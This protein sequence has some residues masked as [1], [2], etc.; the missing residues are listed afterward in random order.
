MS[1]IR[2][3]MPAEGFEIAGPRVLGDAWRWPRGTPRAADWQPLEITVYD[4]DSWNRPVE[5]PFLLRSELEGAREDDDDED[6]V[7]EYEEVLFV[8]ADCPFMKSWT[9]VCRDGVVDVLRHALDADGE[10]LPLWEPLREE[11]YW[12]FNP[13][14]VA[15]EVLDEERSEIRRGR[16]SA[17]IMSIP[18]WAVHEDR[19]A[20]LGAFVLPQINELCLTGEPL[21]RLLDADL[22]GLDLKPVWRSADHER[23]T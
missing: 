10:L 2:V 8:P 13:L 20:S 22:A 6:D 9:I 19:L 18:R 1:E 11:R 21:R 16:S 23:S 15:P 4:T 14:V 7:E 12:M 3:V 17:H 5:L